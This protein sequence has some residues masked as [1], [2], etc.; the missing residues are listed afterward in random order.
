VLTFIHGPPTSQDQF[1]PALLELD[2]V[3]TL[4]RVIRELHDAV[5]D[6]DPG[7]AEYRVGRRSVGAGEVVCHGDLGYWNT[8]WDGDQLVG[9]IDWDFAEPGPP[10]GELAVSAMSVVPFRDDAWAGSVGFQAAPDRRLRLGALC[11]AYGGVS[12]IEV[13]GA[14]ERVVGSEQEKLR[15]LGEQGLEPW[16]SN[17]ANGQ[18]RLFETLAAWIDA[19]RNTLT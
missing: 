1:P 8:V 11:D 7:E 13:V 14:A 15:T 5:A 12:P 16:A 3:A 18:A 4:G 10:V 6:F 17:L 9:L 19:N 2:G